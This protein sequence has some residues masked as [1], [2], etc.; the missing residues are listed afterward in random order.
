VVDRGRAPVAFAW[1][2]AVGE[3]SVAARASVTVGEARSTLAEPSMLVRLNCCEARTA[4][5]MLAE[6][7][8]ADRPTDSCR[9]APS[10]VALASPATR[11]NAPFR[12]TASS[13]LLASVVA[14]GYARR[15]TAASVDTLA[16]CALCVSATLADA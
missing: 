3:L 12:A 6:L 5:S 10:L 1:S 14:R 7:S 2:A 13:E 11:E 8:V 16:S 4:E 9:P 15:A